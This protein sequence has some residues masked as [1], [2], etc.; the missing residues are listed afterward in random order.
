MNKDPIIMALANPVPE[1][2]PDEAYE[3]GAKVV[4]TGR[5]DYPN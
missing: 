4:G 5:S 3:A 1:I 2:Y